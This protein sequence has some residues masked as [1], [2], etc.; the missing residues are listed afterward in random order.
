VRTV[1]TRGR[2]AFSILGWANSVIQFFSMDRIYNGQE[3][4]HDTP[5]QES[6]EVDEEGD[7]EAAEGGGCTSSFECAFGKK[8]RDGY[9]Q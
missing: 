1:P 2:R 7:E 4:T 8:C 3:G 6:E 5:S 9:C